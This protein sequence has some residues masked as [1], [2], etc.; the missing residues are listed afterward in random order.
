[1]A[2]PDKT[3]SGYPD[4]QGQ[5]TA[6]VVDLLTSILDEV[7][8]QVISKTPEPLIGEA[9]KAVEQFQ[10]IRQALVPQPATGPERAAELPASPRP[11]TSP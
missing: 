3:D 1:M 8:K 9:R 11:T 5:S 4:E 2:R 7:K 10:R 6:R